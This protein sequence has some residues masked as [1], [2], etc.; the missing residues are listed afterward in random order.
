MRNLEKVLVLT[1]KLAVLLTFWG[2]MTEERERRL[3]KSEHDELANTS[4]LRL[5]RILRVKCC[6]G[7]VT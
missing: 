7:K 3:W 6:V 5:C 2:T 4:S 1:Q